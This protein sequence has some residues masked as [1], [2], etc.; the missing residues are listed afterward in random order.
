M[1]NWAKVL[2]LGSLTIPY[3]KSKRRTLRRTSGIARGSIENNV[4]GFLID[5]DDIDAL[6]SRIETLQ[7]D[8][9][10]CAA[11]GNAAYARAMRDF[12]ASRMAYR[13]AE[14]LGDS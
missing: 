3:R 4:D 11:M 10:L 5:L 6:A 12:T 8:R 7:T 14:I 1:T 13:Y 2:S 9:H